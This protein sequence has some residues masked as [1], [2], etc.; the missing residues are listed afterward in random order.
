MQPDISSMLGKT[1][2][3][4]EENPLEKISE[5]SKD[6]GKKPKESKESLENFDEE[7]FKQ[8]L[9]A[10]DNSDGLFTPVEKED[11]DNPNHA[12]VDE[13][14]KVKQIKVN[15]PKG[16]YIKNFKDDIAKNPNNYKVQTPKGE[17]TIAEAIRKGYNPITKRFEKDKSPEEIKKKHLEGLNET[18][19]A[20]LEEI[21]SPS[22]AHIAPKDA[23][24]M[25]LPGDSP[26]I[27]GQSIP[28]QAPEPAQPATPSP[29]GAVDI[30]SMLGGG[31]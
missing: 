7:T 11:K 9:M 24:A 28:Q 17:M 26:M 2:T 12:E 22:A 20:K 18:D 8:I 5:A 25:G 15:K 13:D 4:T 30:A 31:M 6:A 3:P 14:A 19:K 10:G 1:G 27:D 23:A 29:E 21:T 16:K